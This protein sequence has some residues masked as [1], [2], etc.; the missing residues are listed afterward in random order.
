MLSTLRSFLRPLAG[1]LCASAA[2]LLAAVALALPA[3]ADP[4]MWVV[5]DKDSTIYVLGTVHILKPET[6]WRSPAI[7]KALAGS[8][9]LWIEVDTDDAALMQSLV[10]KYGVDPANPLRG[11]LDPEQKAR[12][13]AVVTGLGADPAS[14]DPYRP[15]LAGL[16]IS[17]APIAKAGY[18]PA[19]GVEAKLKAAARAAGKPIRTL[20]TAE[21]QIRFFAD[22]PPEL[23]IA[24]LLSSLDDSQD[25][26]ATLDAMVAAWSAGDSESLGA[27]MIND[28]AASYPELYRA[29]LVERNKVWAGQI[30]T[31]LAGKGVSI[32]AVGAGHLVGP[33]SVQAQLADRGI[34]AERLPD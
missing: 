16:Q 34:A 21:Q 10:L 9:E 1:R 26:P 13:E 29:L 30:Q 17:L 12:F 28:M 6:V 20:E 4:A 23:E 32:I 31:L 15:W 8:S 22:L 3:A 11:K 33:D 14:M 24:F 18:D 27:L 25:G 19:S 2:A 7:E 5:R